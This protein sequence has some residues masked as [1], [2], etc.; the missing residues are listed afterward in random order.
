MKKYVSICTLTL[1]L[2]FIICS[3]AEGGID[4]FAIYD[5]NILVTDANGIPIQ[6]A[7]VRLY[8]QDW[9]ISYPQSEFARSDSLGFC[10]FS[11]PRG[12]WSIVIG[13]GQTLNTRQ[14]GQA[15]FLYSEVNIESDETIVMYPDQSTSLKFYDR[16]DQITDVDEIYAA[17]SSMVPNCM[18]PNIGTTA[19]GEC[20]LLTN[21]SDG[22]SFF[23]VRRPTT[24]LD[25]YYI[26]EENIQTTEQIII[27]TDTPDI[28]HISIVLDPNSVGDIHNAIWH[29]C[30]PYQDLERMNS[31]SSFSLTDHG[32]IYTNVDYL[33]YVLFLI[34]GDP[35]Y[36]GE[37]NYWFQYRGA[38]LSQK[39]SN[40]ITAGG[41]IT[42]QFLFADRAEL[43][44]SY[45][46]FLLGPIVDAYGN[47]IRNY[48]SSNG[49]APYST[50]YLFIYDETQ[51][52]IFYNKAISPSS[53][54]FMVDRSFPE[55]SNF[56]LLW[57]MGPYWH[58]DTLIWNNLYDDE[59]RYAYEHTYTTHFDL[60]TPNC[61]ENKAEDFANHLEQA[62]TAMIDLL[63]NESPIPPILENQRNFYVNP[64]G[65][66]SGLEGQELYYD[67]Y[68]QWHPRDPGSRG[69]IRKCYH[70]IGHRV[71]AEAYYPDYAM[72]G[73]FNEATANI[74]ADYVLEELYGESF[75]IPHRIL[76]AHPFFSSVGGL[77]YAEEPEL[78]NIFFIIEVYLPQKYGTVIHKQ[79]FRN[80]IKAYTILNPL[81]YDQIEIYTALYSLLAEE[82]LTW[83][84]NLC[85]IELDEQRISMAIDLISPLFAL[86]E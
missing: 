73:Y 12:L 13:G 47:E 67:G 66:W 14:S 20:T 30:F 44:D 41:P 24:L 69:W 55:T 86:V 64:V 71:E 3:K 36:G 81:G 77:D 23:F 46:Q 39:S 1:F 17:P 21:L 48:V 10:S 70:E 5:V 42:R 76:V 65:Y 2:Y 85:G 31:F 22:L 25:G 18:M 74:L 54:A 43:S 40:T 9:F 38:D 32:Q 8:S 60:H 29:L 28:K 84:F 68:S 62:Y 33:N 80:W 79:F 26:F 56:F 49:D 72:S 16:L 57:D 11:I 61:V 35:I 15:L 45:T 83:L 6:D 27:T 59:Y 58:G 63:G 52:T 82:D 53:R 37:V 75:A 51:L 4:E 50:H 78:Y 19:E 34:V 7:Y